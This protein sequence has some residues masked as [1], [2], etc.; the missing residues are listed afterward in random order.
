MKK[1]MTLASTLIISAAMTAQVNDVTPFEEVNV[2]VPATV[3]IVNGENFGV[4]VR[5]LDKYTATK[6]DYEVKDGT[7]V[8][9]TKMDHDEME[10]VCITIIS[11]IEPEF[12]I[13]RD[14]EL[15]G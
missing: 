1:I 10:N 15:Q 6:V 7:L 8:F 14:V 4:Y 5:S 3:R 11:P 12:T 2:N 9:T 13:G